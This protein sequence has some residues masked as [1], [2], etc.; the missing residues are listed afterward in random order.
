LLVTVLGFGRKP[1]RHLEASR[2]PYVPG[3]R[4]IWVKC[5]N[6]RSSSSSVDD[7]EGSDLTSARC[8]SGTTP[9][10]AGYTTSHAT[11]ACC[12]ALLLSSFAA[13]RVSQDRATRFPL[14]HFADGG[15]DTPACAVA[16]AS[17]GYQRAANACTTAKSPTTLL[18]TLVAANR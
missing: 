5:F 9:T 16:H 17:T 12:C 6:R 13:P 11:L 7:P 15:F 4:G 1:G 18:L 3:D 14:G 10:L 8:C 2:Q